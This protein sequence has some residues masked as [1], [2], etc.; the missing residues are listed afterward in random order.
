VSNQAR[1]ESAAERVLIWPPN[2]IGRS[3]RT[4]NN[5]EI[6]VWIPHPALPMIRP[7]FTVGRI[8]M[9]RHNDLDVHLGCT[10]HDRVKIVNFEPEQHSVS[11]RFVV[12]I[13]YRTVMMFYFEAV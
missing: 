1:A 9:P 4:G 6:A 2:S 10:L 5:Y 12:P 3:V 7:A 13:G 8:S 11:V